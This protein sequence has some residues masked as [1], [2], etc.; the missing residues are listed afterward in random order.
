[1]RILSRLAWTGTPALLA[2]F[3]VL[4][5]GVAWA[6]AFSLSAHGNLSVLPRECASC[7]IGHGTPQTAMF[8]ISEE[9]TCLQCHGDAGLRSAAQANG[10]L[11]GPGNPVNIAAEFTKPSPHPLQGISHPTSQGLLTRTPTAPPTAPLAAAPAS[12]SIMAIV[13]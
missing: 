7:H 11:R 13:P 8:R 3:C 5:A 1:M 2:A 10:V 9:A 6:G 4:P 12:S